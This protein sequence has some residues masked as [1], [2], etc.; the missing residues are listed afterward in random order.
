MHATQC[1]VEVPKWSDEDRLRVMEGNGS[2]RP[3]PHTRR[4]PVNFLSRI[5][6]YHRAFT[7]AKLRGFAYNVVLYYYGVSVMRT[8]YHDH[9]YPSVSY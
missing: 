9:E 6:Y 1:C 7:A 8:K 2:R 5:E 3:T 4:S